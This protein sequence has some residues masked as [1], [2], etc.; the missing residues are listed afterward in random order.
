MELTENA[1]TVLKARYL[2]KDESGKVIETPEEMFARVARSVAEAEEDYGRDV[3]IWTDRF[4]G[5][6]K[7]GASP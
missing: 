2:E 7:V 1:E 4:F 5:L 3:A 6:M